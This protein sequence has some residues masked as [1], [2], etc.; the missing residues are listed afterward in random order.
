M[1]TPKGFGQAALSPEFKEGVDLIWNRTAAGLQT[2]VRWRVQ[3]HSPTGFE[4][5][6]AGS[7]PAELALNAMAALFPA[8]KEPRQVECFE[9]RVSHTAW[10]LHQ[11]F[12]SAFLVTADRNEGQIVWAEIKEWLSQEREKPKAQAMHKS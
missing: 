5:G 7:G 4:I 2:N 1:D 3:H 12:K 6:Y 9:G 8:S 11:S 10:L